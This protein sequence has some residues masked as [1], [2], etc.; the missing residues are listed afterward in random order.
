M[1]GMGPDS[2]DK[3]VRCYTP[4]ILVTWRLSKGVILIVKV[5]F[6]VC[7]FFSRV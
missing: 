6:R 1:G 5:D 4:N 3:G 2:C 7:M